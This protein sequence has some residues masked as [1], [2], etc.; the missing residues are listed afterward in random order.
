MDYTKYLTDAEQKAIYA[1]NAA[2]KW[3]YDKPTVMN[4]IE[5]FRTGTD[6]DKAAVVC[7]FEDVNYHSLC[8]C[9][10]RGDFAGAKA[11]VNEYWA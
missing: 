1:E 5:M 10:E 9:L 7:R 8:D 6:K 2:N 4:F 11:H 3:G